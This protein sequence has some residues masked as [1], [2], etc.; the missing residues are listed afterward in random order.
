MTEDAG[1]SRLN[2]KVDRH[3]RRDKPRADQLDSSKRG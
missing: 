3:A 1:L 2:L